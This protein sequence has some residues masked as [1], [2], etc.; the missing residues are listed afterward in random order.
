MPPHFDKL[1]TSPPKEEDILSI[2]NDRR[3]TSY[4]IPATS[5]QLPA[6]SYYRLST[7]NQLRHNFRQLGKLRRES[8]DFLGNV[9]LTRGAAVS[10][11]H[12]EHGLVK[13]TLHVKDVHLFVPKVNADGIF[14]LLVPHGEHHGFYISGVFT[15]VGMPLHFERNV[16]FIQSY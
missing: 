12:G 4:E 10:I 16:V 1:S 5:Q 6:T 7:K 2:K 8:S 14:F 13:E 11:G 3:S 9:F 15:I